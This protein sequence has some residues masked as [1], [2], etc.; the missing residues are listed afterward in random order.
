M[1]KKSQKWNAATEEKRQTKKIDGYAL[2]SFF[3]LLNFHNFF[4][5]MP[6]LCMLSQLYLLI[7]YVITLFLYHFLSLKVKAAQWEKG[8]KQ[9]Q[10]HPFLLTNSEKYICKIIWGMSKLWYSKII[11]NNDEDSISGKFCIL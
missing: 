8:R 3:L 9:Q 7:M 4:Q 2:Y 11:D 6:P 10:I 5:K 1:F